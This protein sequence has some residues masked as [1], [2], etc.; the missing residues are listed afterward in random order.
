MRLALI[1]FVVKPATGKISPVFPFKNRVVVGIIHPIA[2]M[3]MPGRIGII[4]IARII[5]FE[6]KVY[7][8]AD[9]AGG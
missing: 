4:S 6:A 8:Y 9:L 2:I 7:I 3:A 1:S 5:P